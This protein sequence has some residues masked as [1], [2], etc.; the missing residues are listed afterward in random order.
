MRQQRSGSLVLVSSNAGLE[1]SAGQANYAA[2]KLGVVG[3]MY[4]TALAMGKYNVNV[5]ALAPFADTR[6]TQRLD[7]RFFGARDS[8]GPETVAAMAAALCSPAARSVTGQ[9]YTAAGRRIARYR[10]T[11]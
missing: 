11:W 7:S 3:L 4:A 6:M 2:A 5:N 1:G 8:V 9:V 10:L